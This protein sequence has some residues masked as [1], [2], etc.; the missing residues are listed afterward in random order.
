MER[1]VGLV[2]ESLRA[3]G[4]SDALAMPLSH[5]R[6]TSY[7]C[8]VILPVDNVDPAA[9]MSTLASIA[10]KVAGELFEV[11]IVD[12]ST[13]QETKDLLASLAGDVRIVSGEPGWNYAAA[14]NRGAAEA[15]GKYL[16]FVK[17]G[18][19][20]DE[21]WLEGLLEVAEYESDAGV[22]G[23][24]T[25]NENGLVWHIG[26]AFDV[27]QAP[28]S[29]YRLLPREFSGAQK[30]RH[31]RAVETPFVASRE[32]FCRLGGFSAELSNRF[33]DIDFCLR[34]QRAGLRI[35]YTPASTVKRQQASWQPEIE[36][37]QANRIRFFSKWTGFLWQDDDTYLEEDNLTHDALSALYREL[38]GRLAFSASQ[39]AENAA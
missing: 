6:E 35:I 33:E 28:F 25:L 13:R 39:L 4:Q 36:H 26:T 32:L 22:V 34:V 29:I 2:A 24:M 16:A 37:E 21:G 12:C 11:V 17:P 15:L 5:Q 38:A 23:G 18:V 10:E 30:R 27:N 3:R 14:C 20:V 7:P 9:L 19:I 8:T 1:I 31:F